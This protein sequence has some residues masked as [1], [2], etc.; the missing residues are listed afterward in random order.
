[1]EIRELPATYWLLI[2]LFGVFLVQIVCM[3][4]S[5]PFTEQLILDPSAIASGQMLWGII[6]NIFLHAGVLHIFFNSWALFMFGLVLE[7]IIGGREVLKVFFAS[8]IFASLFYTITA[9]FILNNPLPALGA[10]GAIFG[11]IGAVMV[12][13]PHMRVMLIFPPIPMELWMM[14]IFFIILALI[15]FAAGG[16]GGVAEN[17]HLGGLLIGFLFGYYYKKKEEVGDYTYLRG[18]EVWSPDESD[19]RERYV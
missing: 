5:V 9:L 19:W 6:T 18:Y 7:N 3:V 12:L 16:G 1:M 8:G 13:R 11:I 10:S 17:A 15:W 4:A 14:G 2:V